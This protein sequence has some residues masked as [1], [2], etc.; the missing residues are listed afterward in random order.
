MRRSSLVLIL[1]LVAV[2]ASAQIVPSDT[3][4]TLSWE[5]HFGPETLVLMV[6]PDGS[7]PPFAEARMW[8]TGALVDGRLRMDLRDGMGAPFV[9]YSANGV[10][11]EP[12]LQG[13]VMATCP[14]PGVCEIRPDELV[15]NAAGEF[16][17]SAPP[18]AGGWSD[19][20]LQGYAGFSPLVS[21][22]GMAMRFVS[23]DINGDLIVN[24]TDSGFFA[25]DLFITYHFRSDFNADGVINLSDSGFMATSIGIN[26][27]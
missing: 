27:N 7:G 16:H 17:F 3:Q 5:A 9:G 22:A 24:L 18:V 1:F 20:L 25:Q 4:S 6:L 15:S 8:P 2:S 21:S 10:W 14:Q 26:C 19:G 12:D 23:P 13:G 11:L